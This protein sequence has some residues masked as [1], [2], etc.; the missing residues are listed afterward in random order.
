[1][2]GKADVVKVSTAEE[3]VDAI[4]ANQKAYIQLTADIYLT[5]TS[6]IDK[7]FSGIIDGEG[8]RRLTEKRKRFT[9]L[10]M[11]AKGIIVLNIR[12][13]KRLRVPHLKTS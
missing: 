5:N 10:F 6:T 8:K 11:V 4:N 13:S 2:A 9:S 3:L 7:T 1:M 12:Y